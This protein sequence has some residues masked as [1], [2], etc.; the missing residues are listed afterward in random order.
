MFPRAKAALLV[1]KISMIY[2]FMVLLCRD[3]IFQKRQ[4]TG[5]TVGEKRLPEWV[6]D[7]TQKKEGECSKAIIFNII[8]GM[9]FLHFIVTEKKL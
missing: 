6:S 8:V 7:N 4:K 2:F 5:K 3:M 1:G 9:Y